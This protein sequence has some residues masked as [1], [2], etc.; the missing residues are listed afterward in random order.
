MQTTSHVNGKDLFTQYKRILISYQLPWLERI[1][2]FIYFK[3]WK[4]FIDD[5]LARYFIAA[6]D[7]QYY[8]SFSL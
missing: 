4:I 6:L 8:N 5:H 2:F 7:R 1:S 3:L